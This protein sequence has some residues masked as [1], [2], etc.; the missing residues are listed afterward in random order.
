MN[1]N[2]DQNGYIYIKQPIIALGNNINSISYSKDGILWTGLGSSIFT[3]GYAC[4]SNDKLYVAVGTGNNSLAYSYDGIFWTG[5]GSSFF[6][7]GYYVSWSGDKFIAVGNNNIIFSFNGIQWSLANNNPFTTSS[8]WSG[9]VG[10]TYIVLGEGSFPMASSNDG[11]NWTGQSITNVSK[12]TS[13]ASNGIV[14]V[15]A[16]PNKLVSSIGDT[17]N[18]N[19]VYN[20][21]SSSV[22]TIVYGFGKYLTSETFISFYN[23]GTNIVYSNNG[24]DW[25]LISSY[26]PV[27]SSLITNISGSSWFYNKFIACG[28]NNGSGVSI[29][30]SY[31]GTEW[32]LISNSSSILSNGYG[33]STSISSSFFIDRTNSNIEVTSDI[34][35][36][37]FN[38]FSLQIKSNDL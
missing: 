37:G 25:T 30:Y 3:T 22:N 18:F 20:I 16:T 29:I 38:I 27:G 11:I 34:Y 13:L 4:C 19:N 8:Y 23:D 21:A 32:F 36:E 24:I 12:A 33:L 9:I 17:N 5:L 28:T 14:T 2:G 26:L 6:S 1:W 35:Q 7:I 15:I 31:N 10:N